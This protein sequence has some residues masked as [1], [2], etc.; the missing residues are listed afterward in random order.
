MLLQSK[1]MRLLRQY[2]PI[3]NSH[4]KRQETP[5]SKCGFA[6]RDKIDTMFSR[7]SHAFGRQHNDYYI[8]DLWLKKESVQSKYYANKHHVYYWHPSQL[9]IC[10]GKRSINNDRLQ[11][12]GGLVK[13]LKSVC[14]QI[15]FWL[16][17]SAP[18]CCL[19]SGATIYVH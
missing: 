1:D 19:F 11:S 2:V 9:V 17:L 7:R 8:T 3:D 10:F 16:L 12:L 14:K 15:R 18:L 5:R 6:I 4:K 13:H